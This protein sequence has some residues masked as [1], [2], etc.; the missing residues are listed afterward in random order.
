MKRDIIFVTHHLGGIG[1][2]QRVVDQLATRFAEDGNKV[3]VVGCAIQ[4]QEKSVQVQEKY[5]EILL[6][7]EDIFFEKPWLFLKEKF[8]SKKLDTILSDLLAK[9][10]N[11]MV[12]LANPIVY[13]LMEKSLKKFSN[14]AFFI[15]QMHSSADFVLEC[16]GLYK[17]YPYIIKNKYPKLDCIMFLSDSYSELISQ[18]YK[19]PLEKFVAITN[20]LPRYIEASE[21]DYQEKSKI[22]SFVGRLDPVKQIDHQIQAFAQVADEFPDVSFN[23]YGSGNL[24]ETLQLLIDQLGMTKRI[25][26][27]GKTTQ[28]KEV[29]QK[30]LFTLLTSKS[31]AFG[32]SVVESMVLGTPVLSYNCSQGVADLQSA[33]PEMLFNPSVGELTNKMRYF[34]TNPEILEGIG[35]RGQDYVIGNY[36]EDVIVQKWYALFKKLEDKKG[37]T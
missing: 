31:E 28:V 17:V 20:P 33:T 5:Q 18:H 7:Q 4:S 15:G 3:T 29:Y 24:K 8:F 23:I 13:L 16:K 6:Y 35:R 27:K 25:T 11:P 26:L 32:M 30:S 34:L 21:N 10:K 12:I 19:I 22:I 1:G 9:S 37:I 36:A 14:H 2:V